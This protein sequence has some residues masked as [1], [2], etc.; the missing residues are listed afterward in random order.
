MVKLKEFGADI[1]NIAIQHHKNGKSCQEIVKYLAGNVN[2]STVYRW[3]NQFKTN[4]INL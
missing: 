1:R 4:G 3:I 2:I